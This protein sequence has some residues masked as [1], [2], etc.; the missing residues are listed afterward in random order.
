MTE[1]IDEA[2][3]RH[4][5]YVLQMPRPQDLPDLPEGEPLAREWKTYK[6]EVARLLAEGHVGRHALVKEDEVVSIW[7]THREALQAGRL[8]FGLQPFMIHEVQPVERPV[9]LGSRIRCHN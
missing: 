9:R 1:R 2:Q 3:Q 5:S 6:R 7:D 8:Q 4:L